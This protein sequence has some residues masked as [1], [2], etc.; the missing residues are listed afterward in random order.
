ME[1]VP[2]SLIELPA[3]TP[4]SLHHCSSPWIRDWNLVQEKKELDL[5]H[6]LIEIGIAMAW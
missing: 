5:W 6:E 1:S 2:D 3:S 4:Y